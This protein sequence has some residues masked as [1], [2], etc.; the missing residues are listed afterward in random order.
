MLNTFQAEE[1]CLHNFSFCYAGVRFT[2]LCNFI[3]IAAEKVKLPYLS[4]Y[5]DSVGTNFRNGANFATGGSSIRPG[6]FSPFHLGIQISQFIQFKSR[7]SAV[8]NQLSPNSQSLFPLC[9]FCSLDESCS[10]LVAPHLI[11]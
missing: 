6:G 3:C 4:P 7:T 2:C 10:I 1:L 5:L 8:Y 11:E 9:V